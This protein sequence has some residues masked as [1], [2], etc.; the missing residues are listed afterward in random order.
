MNR[1]ERARIVARIQ[2]ERERLRP[3]QPQ[4]TRTVIQLLRRTVPESEPGVVPWVNL[5]TIKSIEAE[6]GTDGVVALALSLGNWAAAIAQDFA[7]TNGHT[8]EQLMDYYETQF[9][10]DD[11]SSDSED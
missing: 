1:E 7:R 8:A 2:E 3:L 9:F 10:E 5:A 4:M 11:A 6:H